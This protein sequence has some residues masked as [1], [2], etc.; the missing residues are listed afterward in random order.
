MDHAF[1]RVVLERLTALD[2]IAARAGAALPPPV[3]RAHLRRVIAGWR[4]LLAGHQPDSRGRCPVCSGL[5]RR[6]RWPCQIWIAAHQ[7]LIGDAQSAEQ[8]VTAP[9]TPAR[10]PRDVEV[11]ARGADRGQR[12]PEWTEASMSERERPALPAQL[13]ADGGQI[14]RAAVIE[15]R[16][17]VPRPRLARRPRR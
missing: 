14:H 17:T 1:Q 9:R 16:P 12:E 8:P 4:H 6:R 15:R 5:L 7:Q 10:P 11:V 3:A 13:H 2:G